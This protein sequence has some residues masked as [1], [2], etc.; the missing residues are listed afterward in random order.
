LGREI[1]EIDTVLIL[2]SSSGNTA[3]PDK[4]SPSVSGQ[5]LTVAANGGRVTLVF[6]PPSITLV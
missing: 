2:L 5:I 6:V 1:S 3:Q 4:G